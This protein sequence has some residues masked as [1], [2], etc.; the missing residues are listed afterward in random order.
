MKN[1]FSKKTWIF[2]G[3]LKIMRTFATANEKQRRDSSAG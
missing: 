3:G 1:F 2:F